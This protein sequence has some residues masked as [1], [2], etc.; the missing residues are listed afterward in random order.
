MAYCKGI[1]AGCAAMGSMSPCPP[2]ERI[3]MG[4]STLEE[5]IERKEN[6]ENG[7]GK[8]TEPRKE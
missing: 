5:E 4:L 7:K 1:Y 6:E 8:R 2:C 3:K